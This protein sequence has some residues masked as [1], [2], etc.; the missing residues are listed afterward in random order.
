MLGA[1]GGDF[2]GSVVAGRPGDA[3][4][5]PRADG[6]PWGAA[7]QQ[8]PMAEACRR[9]GIVPQANFHALRHT[10]ASHLVMNGAPLIVVATNLG[11]SDT[12]M[13]EKF[14]GHM[15]KDYIARAVRTAAPSFGIVERGNVAPLTLGRSG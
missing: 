7:H 9:A 13:V 10:Y 4:M 14:Y 1:E 2:F 15:S 11:H 12:R 3:L 5:F 8:K 6:R